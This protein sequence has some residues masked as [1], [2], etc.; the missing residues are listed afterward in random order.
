MREDMAPPFAGDANP[1][2]DRDAPPAG[3]LTRFQHGFERVDRRWRQQV[4]T[5]P[6]K[7]AAWVFVIAYA[8]FVARRPDI[9]FDAKLWGEDGA[10]W[11]SQAYNDGVLT[12]LVRPQNGYLQTFSRLVFSALVPVPLDY[13]PAIANAIGLA[14]R[15]WCVAFLFTGR[16]D[17]LG[18]RARLLI[19]AFMVFQPGLQEVHANIT[20]THWYLLFLA[21][22]VVVANRPASRAWTLHDIVILVLA[23]LSGPFC[24]LLLPALAVQ[25]IGPSI[26]ATVARGWAWLFDPR[27]ITLSVTAFIQFLIM[28]SE[29]TSTRSTAPLGAS[30]ELLGQALATRVFA[31]FVTSGNFKTFLWNQPALCAAI[32]VIG[33][34]VL[35]Y[36]LL[37]G[38]GRLKTVI[39]FSTLMMV[40]I[41]LSPQIVLQGEQWPKFAIPGAGQRYFVIAPIACLAV[42]IWLASV[43]A[44]R[45]VVALATLGM[46]MIIAFGIDRFRLSPLPDTGY[47]EAIAR[48]DYETAETV[49][50]PTNPPGWMMELH[51]RP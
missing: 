33:F 44:R 43:H 19:A 6:G 17:S 3:W 8:I 29:G 39:V 16:L 31:G 14:V 45:H 15:A 13:V 7:A 28:V 26:R 22:V 11:F 2:A 21:L 47:R 34:V 18:S 36:A 37:R 10:L 23:G 25:W 27:S 4:E 12:A 50:I 46:V 48:I 35:A 38:P 9:L 40:P 20:N 42:L 49:R 51:I 24:I 41:F 1:A 30:F 5:S 32:T